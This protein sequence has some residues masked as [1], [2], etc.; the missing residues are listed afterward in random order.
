M[1]RALVNGEA[2]D[3]CFSLYISVF[4]SISNQLADNLIGN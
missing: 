2:L 1:M 4:R 3:S